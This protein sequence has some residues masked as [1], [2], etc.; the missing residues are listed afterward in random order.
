MIVIRHDA[1]MD[2]IDWGVKAAQELPPHKTYFSK[3]DTGTSG[4]VQGT[5]VYPPGTGVQPHWHTP[6]ET[7]FV[8]SGE[9]QAH[10]G[11]ERFRLV[12]GTSIFVPSRAVHWFE[13]DRAVPL[14]VFWTLAC[15]GMSDLDFT[16]ADPA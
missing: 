13:N 11:S 16:P 2:W 12:P 3:E 1:E 7:Y 15:D 10:L 14:I 5:L 9:G 6:V 8:I 4:L